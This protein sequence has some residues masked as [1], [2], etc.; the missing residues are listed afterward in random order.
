MLQITSSYESAPPNYSFKRTAATG[1]GTI[2]RRSATA[3]N[4]SVRAHRGR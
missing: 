1:C 4:S 3:A 2:W